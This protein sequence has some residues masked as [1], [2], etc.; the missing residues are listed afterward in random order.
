[1]VSSS[2]CRPRRGVADFLELFGFVDVV[3]EE[4]PGAKELKD[5]T[6]DKIADG[7]GVGAGGVDDLH[8]AG[9]AGF[10]VDVFETDAAS[11]DHFEIG[12]HGKQ[13]GVHAG[14]GANGKTL[15][16]GQGF[17]ELGRVVGNF[18]NFGAFFEPI[19]RKRVGS[20]GDENDG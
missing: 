10:D 15:G 14:V 20:F 19:E 1:M 13:L 11:A 16:L 3:F 2:S 4:T 9:A 12:R 7:V 17:V 18:Q 6:K 5:V 8:A